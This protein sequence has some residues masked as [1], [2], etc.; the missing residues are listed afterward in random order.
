MAIEKK[1][2]APVL[3]HQPPADLFG[4]KSIFMQYQV[5]YLQGKVKVSAARINI[6][7]VAR[8]FF[9]YVYF[10]VQ[11]GNEG[12][13]EISS[14]LNTLT[15]SL[16]EFLACTSTPLERSRSTNQNIS[17]RVSIHIFSSKCIPQI[18]NCFFSIL[19]VSRNLANA[20]LVLLSLPGLQWS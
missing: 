13:G 20:K 5:M 15:W 18:Q 10:Q 16:R 17:S 9:N 12:Q 11:E 6:N 8:F 1:A 4:G 2:I 3:P 7:L 14:S 19:R